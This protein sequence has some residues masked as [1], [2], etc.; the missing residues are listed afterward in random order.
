MA[1]KPHLTSHFGREVIFS[2]S[3]IS[4]ALVRDSHKGF[5]FVF[6][7]DPVLVGIYRDGSKYEVVENGHSIIPYRPRPKGGLDSVYTSKHTD[8]EAA[9]AEFMEL[10]KRSHK[11]QARQA[12]GECILIPPRLPLSA[13]RRKKA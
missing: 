3:S 5:G 1:W 10:V 7:H 11:L 6:A 9:V 8:K 4:I 13:V 2:A 12:L